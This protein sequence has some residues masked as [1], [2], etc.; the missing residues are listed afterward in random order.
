M[1][2]IFN[3]NINNE[4]SNIEFPNLE[5]AIALTY[6]SISVKDKLII[7]CKLYTVKSA[8]VIPFRPRLFK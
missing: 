4:L 3:F 6:D 5:L 1:Q 2:E 8:L 7:H